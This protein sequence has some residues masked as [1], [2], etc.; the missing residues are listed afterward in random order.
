MI[1]LRVI[2]SGR[3]D[4]FLDPAAV[5]DF[6]ARLRG[7]LLRHGDVGYDETR[8]LFNGMMIIDRH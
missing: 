4:T 7:S 2:T 6:A 5:Q 1:A 8:K 3:S